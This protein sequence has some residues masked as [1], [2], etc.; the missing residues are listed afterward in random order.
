M[1]NDWSSRRAPL[2]HLLRTAGRSISRVTERQPQTHNSIERKTDDTLQHSFSICPDHAQS[3]RSIL[4]KAVSQHDRMR[5]WWYRESA[6]YNTWAKYGQRAPVSTK[7]YPPGGWARKPPMPRR[8]KPCLGPAWPDSGFSLGIWSK[9]ARQK[10]RS[11][12]Y[13]YKILPRKNSA[14]SRQNCVP[15]KLEKTFTG[16]K[17]CL[18]K[19]GEK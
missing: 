15:V 7:T 5:L 11:K 13:R 17:F 10:H 18:V 4:G 8:A 16:T 2:E 12:I 9:N 3:S 19:Y 1:R 14:K 6:F